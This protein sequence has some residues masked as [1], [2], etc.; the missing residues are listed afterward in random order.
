MREENGGISEQHSTSTELE[1]PPHE[2]G[3]NETKLILEKIESLE[4]EKLKFEHSS[5]KPAAPVDKPGISD[6]KAF[7]NMLNEKIVNYLNK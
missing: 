4:N 1:K 6:K 3:S 7:R 2:L 5:R